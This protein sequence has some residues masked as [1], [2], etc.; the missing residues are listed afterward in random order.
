MSNLPEAFIEAMIKKTLKT[1]NKKAKL[2]MLWLFIFGVALFLIAPIVPIK[3]ALQIF[4]FIFVGLSVYVATVFVLKEYTVSIFFPEGEISPD[5]AIYEFHGKRELK[6]CHIGLSDVVEMT[7]ITPENAKAEKEKRKSLKRYKYNTF[8]DC[9]KFI[10]LI[11]KDGVSVILT[12]DE[13]IYRALKSYI[14]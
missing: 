4:G 2:T 11:T 6:V 5:L 8:F 1:Q 14:K 3:A 7:V 9:K 12:Y 10:G 13:D